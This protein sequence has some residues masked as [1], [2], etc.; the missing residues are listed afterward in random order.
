MA[1][2]LIRRPSVS[3]RCTLNWVA[4]LVDFDWLD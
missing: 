4:D 3:E 2:I 1:E